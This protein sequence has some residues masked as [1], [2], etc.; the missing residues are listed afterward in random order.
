MAVVKVLIVDDHDIV[1]QGLRYYLDVYD[2]IEVV[3][4]AETGIEAVALVREKEPDVVLM[5]LVMPEMDGIEAT[6][7]LLALSP[8]TKVIVLTTFAEE[9]KV[10]PAIEAGATSYLLKDVKPPDLVKA[11]LATHRGESQL[12]PDIAKKLMSRVVQ[13]STGATET[14]VHTEL[15][16]RELEV[17]QLIAEGL[18]NQELAQALTISEKTV[19][20]HVSSILSKLDLADRTQVAI[21]AYKHGLVSND[22]Q[23]GSEKQ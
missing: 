15:T 7:E 9:Q 19:K 10:F 2:E 11:I 20:K 16:K 17:L 22:S 8:G 6:R 12:H 18:S 1:R 3:G 23:R 13:L 5:D 21:Y 4:E 14:A